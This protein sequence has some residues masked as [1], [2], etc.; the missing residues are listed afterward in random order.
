VSAELTN[1]PWPWPRAGPA[2]LDS[3]S[4]K[5]RSSCPVS[6]SRDLGS[7]RAW[8]MVRAGP[9]PRCQAVEASMPGARAR[10]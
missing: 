4:V 10:F 6:S 3:E 9:R 7:D 2:L 8:A 1:E 5:D